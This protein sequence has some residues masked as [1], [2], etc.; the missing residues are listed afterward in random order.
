MSQAKNGS[1]ISMAVEKSKAFLLLKTLI[2]L[3][4]MNKFDR[5]KKLCIIPIILLGRLAQLA[6]ALP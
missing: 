5:K 4:K 1:K 2:F 3:N 6:R